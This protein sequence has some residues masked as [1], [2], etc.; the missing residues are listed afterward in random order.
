M[1]YRPAI[2][3][4]AAVL[5][6]WGAIYIMRGMRHQEHARL[7]PSGNKG[8]LAAL[9]LFLSLTL[10]PCEAMIPVFLAAGGIHWRDLFGLATGMAV[11]TLAGM[12]TL[13][14]LFGLGVSRLRWPWLEEHESV[15]IGCVLAGLGLLVLWTPRVQAN[16]P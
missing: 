12:M 6:I 3:G 8:R 14:Y 16:I 10:S 7:E 1:V 13:A 4:A 15:V 11:A 5:F 9:S 2:I